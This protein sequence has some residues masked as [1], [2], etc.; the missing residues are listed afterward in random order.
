M[1]VFDCVAD[2]TPVVKLV[3]SNFLTTFGKFLV[4]VPFLSNG[5]SSGYFS[6]SLIMGTEDLITTL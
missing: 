4:A 1:T 3:K 5:V 6:E 2:F